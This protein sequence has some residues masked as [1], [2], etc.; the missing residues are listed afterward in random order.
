M[1]NEKMMPH[2]VLITGDQ[3]RA[4]AMGHMGRPALTPNLD[5]L[6]ARGAVFDNAFCV[7]PVCTPSRA[8][9]FTGRYPHCTGAWNIGVSMNED[10]IT[11]C[12]HLKPHGYRCV[13]NGKMHFRP[14][15]A[16]WGSDAYS[17]DPAVAFRGRVRDGTYYGF[18]ETHI[19]EDSRVG[20]YLDWL[21]E[22]APKWAEHRPCKDEDTFE[23]SA[24]PPELHQTQW[25]G[26]RSVETIINHDLDRPLFMWTSFVDPHHPFDAPKKYMDLYRDVDVADPVQ[27]EG[28]HDPRPE[29]LRCQGERGYWPGG[30]EEHGESADKIRAIIRNYYAMVTFIDEQV[31][32][33]RQALATRGMLENTILVFTADHGELLGDHRLLMKG[34]WLYD[35]LS[36][37]PMMLAGPGIPEGLRTQALMENVDVLPTLLDLVGIDI[38]YGV[39]GCTYMPLFRGAKESI[40]DSVITSYDVHDRGIRLKS[41]RTA[42]YKLNVFANESYGELYDLKNDPDETANLFFN[43]SLSTVKAELMQKMVHRMM[44]DEDPLPERTCQW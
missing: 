4:D 1:T 24:M 39:Q 36:K 20:E 8:A 19:T 41:F 21:R 31:G 26:D 5:R 6:A 15:R 22:T 7:N 34:P 40:R 3:M 44:E 9:L 25:I 28:E 2:I 33:L 11:L 35:G 38:P 16:P 37:V 23:G 43:P 29:H 10:E 12:D 30:A 14:E 42:R 17:E 13:A 32:R 18:D 27:R